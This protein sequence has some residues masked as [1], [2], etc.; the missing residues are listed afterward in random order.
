MSSDV[1]VLGVFKLPLSTILIFDLGIILTV[2]YFFLSLLFIFVFKRVMVIATD[3]IQVSVC[4]LKHDQSE[5]AFCYGGRRGRDRMV[6]GFTTTYAI[7]TYH[8]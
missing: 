8:N 4:L 1:F 6:D 7:S 5:N 2:L 3:N